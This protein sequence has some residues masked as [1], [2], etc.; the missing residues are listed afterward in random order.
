MTNAYA[1]LFTMNGMTKLMPIPKAVRGDFVVVCIEVFTILCVVKGNTA[2]IGCLALL[3]AGMAANMMYRFDEY[4]E[5][6]YFHGGLILGAIG[7]AL[8]IW[9]GVRG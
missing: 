9:F 1:A 6:A 3:F 8:L 2:W 5:R 4:E 7:L